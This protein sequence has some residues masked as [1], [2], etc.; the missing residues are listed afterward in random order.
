MTA[1]SSQGSPKVYKAMDQ[2]CSVLRRELP[3]GYRMQMERVFHEDVVLL[4]F[5]GS[6]WESRQ[7]GRVFEEYPGSVV[8]RDAGQVFDVKTIHCD[9][10][11]GSLCREIHIP[12][13]TLKGVLDH[14]GEG[15]A[16]R[17][18]FSRPVLD[19]PCIHARLMATHR[20]LERPECPLAK[21]TALTSLVHDIA[22]FTSRVSSPSSPRPCRRRFTDVVDYMRA[23]FDR[24]ITLEQLADISRT[25][26]FVLLRQFKDSCG[27]TPHQYLRTLRVNRAMDY[28]QAGLKLADVAIICGFADQSHM[29]RQFK[30]TVGVSP[31]KFYAAVAEGLPAPPE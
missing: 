17:L 11:E 15:R 27:V 8:L 3:P 23:H 22:R 4:G 14:R 19:E 12:P 1:M 24:E 25:N 21:S 6:A 9:E 2:K 29:N 28:I 30:R 20:L 13:A 10:K 26:P 31:G 18:D 5:W 16:L 7:S